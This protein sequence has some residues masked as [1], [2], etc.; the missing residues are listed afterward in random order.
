MAVRNARLQH[1]GDA[2]CDT[3]GGAA[4]GAGAARRRV[5]AESLWAYRAVAERKTAFCVADAEG[6]LSFSNGSV[7]PQAFCG[8]AASCGTCTNSCAAAGVTS[9]VSGVLKTCIADSHGC[10]TFNAGTVCPALFC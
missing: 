8:D 1:A 6:C 5:T 9:C 7:C 3:S 4:V 2:R 10:L